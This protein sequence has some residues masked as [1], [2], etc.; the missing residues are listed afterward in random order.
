LVDARRSGRQFEGLADDVRPRTLED[1]YIVQGMAKEL[2]ESSGFGRQG[3]W[4]IGCTTTVMQEYLSVEAPVAGVMYLQ[5]MWR[6]RHTFTSPPPP[7][8]LG[9]E[10]ELAVRIGED[11]PR[12]DR[13]Y[14][15]DDVVHAVAAAM[16]AIEVVE[17]RYVDY[18]A[19]DTPTLAA[20]DFFHY[21]CVLGIEDESLDP[22]TLRDASASM[23]INYV[24]VGSGRGT[25]ILGDPLV[26]LAWL[27]NHCA[28]YETP[29]RA[30]D[31][32]LLGSL[33]Q[34]QWVTPGDHVEVRN[35]LLGE[36]AAL[37]VAP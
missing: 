35:D 4:K 1:A 26:A 37:F 21:G 18:H 11:L 36:V 15:T 33:V 13:P 30:G 25:D 27:A 12:R 2:L 34:T 19:L 6:G 5:S 3:G 10:C 16:A 9:V 28:A 29:V 24:N 8:V 20:D 31:V 7:R 32:V 23:I 14:S 17:D 22:H